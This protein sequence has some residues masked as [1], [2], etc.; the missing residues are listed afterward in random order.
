MCKKSRHA[1]IFCR[2]EKRLTRKESIQRTILETR[3]AESP[4]EYA[5]AFVDHFK[6]YYEGDWKKKKINPD[7]EDL[8]KMLS[9]GL[10]LED[11]DSAS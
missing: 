4:Q 3:E 1:Q 5:K 8:I 9:G 6:K 11:L 2:K 7:T 10:G